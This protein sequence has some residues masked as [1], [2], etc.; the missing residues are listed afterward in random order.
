M[1]TCTSFY[2]LYISAR[3]A[4]RAIQYKLDGERTNKFRRL[5]TSPFINEEVNLLTE[6]LLNKSTIGQDDVPD[7]LSLTYY[8][9]N[10][11]HRS[12]QECAMEMQDTYVRLDRS[13]ASLLELI[14]RKL[15]STTYFS[16]SPPPAMR[17]GSS[18]PGAYTGYRVV[19]ST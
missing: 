7:L 4:Q 14:E 8:A 12:T 11:N 2:Q 18:D 15:G 17:P 5:I 3:M 10:Y 13:I 6:E 16:A 9:G 19:N 1:D